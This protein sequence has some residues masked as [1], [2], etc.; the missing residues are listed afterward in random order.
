[1]GYVQP[2]LY[3]GGALGVVGAGLFQLLNEHTK[4]SLW[5]GIT[6]LF[7]IGTG[8][9][10]QMPFIVSQTAGKGIDTEV[11][12]SIVIFCQ[13]SRKFLQIRQ[14]FAN[15]GPKTLG[16]A[17]IVSVCQSIY[18]NI[19]KKH[20]EELTIPGLDQARI[21]ASGATGFRSFVPAS[22]LEPVIHAA[23]FSIRRAFIPACVFMGVVMIATIPL[24]NA[25]IKGATATGGA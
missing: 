13:A 2:F 10:F 9:A 11:G 24:P 16:G 23:M 22:L 21:I 6:F 15:I 19:F 12:T 3:I 1:M 4:Q 8:C 5:V 14:D 20:I 18:V 25:S 7:G 17:L